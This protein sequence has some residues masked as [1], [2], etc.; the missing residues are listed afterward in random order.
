MTR[1]AYLEGVH[2]RRGTKDPRG[3]TRLE[4]R[5]R[6]RNRRT[7]LQLRR[8]G[9]DLLQVIQLGNRPLSAP[10]RRSS[11]EQSQQGDGGEELSSRLKELRFDYNDY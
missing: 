1:N 7:A 8:R 9:Q 10:F 11:L 3:G 4:N 5:D 2:D 6:L